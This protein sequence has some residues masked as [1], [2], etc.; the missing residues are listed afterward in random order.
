MYMCERSHSPR[1]NVPVN[2]IANHATI[3]TTPATVP[4][5]PLLLFA[6]IPTLPGEPTISMCGIASTN[7]NAVVSRLRGPSVGVTS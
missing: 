3:A 4:N 1:G 5:T 2:R 7:R 6:P